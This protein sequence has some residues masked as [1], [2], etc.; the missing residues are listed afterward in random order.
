MIQ[1]TCE[2]PSALTAES[3]EM[4]FD[5]NPILF[6]RVGGITEVFLML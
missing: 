4:G 5:F 2:L 1:F 3:L 6:Y